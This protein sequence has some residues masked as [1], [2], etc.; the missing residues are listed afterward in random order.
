MGGMPCFIS[1]EYNMIGS[2][3]VDKNKI[4]D[5]KNLEIH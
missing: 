5:K 3:H 1:S 2:W 4:V